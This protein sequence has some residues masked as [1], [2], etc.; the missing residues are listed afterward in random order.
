MAG[1]STSRRRRRE[2]LAVTVAAAAAVRGRRFRGLGD[3]DVL[4]VLMFW[5]S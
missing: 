4:D 3:L 1:A 2:L 5:M